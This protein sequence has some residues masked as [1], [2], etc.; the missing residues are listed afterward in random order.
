[1]HL[2]AGLDCCDLRPHLGRQLAAARHIVVVQVG[3]E[4]ARDLHVHVVRHREVALDVTQRIDDQGDLAVGVGDEEARVSELTRRDRLDRVHG[5]LKGE[6]G[7]RQQDVDRHERDCNCA[8]V[9]DH[10][11]RDALGRRNSEID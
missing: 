6:R 5:R 11:G 9:E 8:A 7:R 3:V 4:G 2:V 1:M 10:L